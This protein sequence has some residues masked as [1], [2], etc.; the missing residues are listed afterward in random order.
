MDFRDTV[1]SVGVLPR[2]P[3]PLTDKS[4][5]ITHFRHALALD[6]LRVKFLPE[7]LN[8][9][10]PD[11]EQ[12]V[13]EVWF[14]GTH[15]DVG[16]GNKSNPTLDRG[17]EPLKWMMEEAQ[18]QGL[19]VRLHDV[20]IGVPH[21]EVTNS[22]LRKWLI[23]EIL[24]IS[25]K[26]YTLGGKSVVLRRP[27]LMAARE[28]LP[29]HSI[30]WTVGASL[31]EGSISRLDSSRKP[32]I[33][34]A[35][36][37]GKDAKQI[38]WKDM[39]PNDKRRKGP[40]WADDHDFT[41]MVNILKDEPRVADDVW[42][43]RLHNYVL[44]KKRSRP[45][46]IWAYGRPQFLQRLFKNYSAK[47]ETASIAR[48]IIGFNAK[49]VA[50][51]S[52]TSSAGDKVEEERLRD[53]VIPRI[54]LMLS[55]W[56]ADAN[57]AEAEP[58]KPSLWARALGF[59]GIGSS[60]VNVT[61]S[62]DLN[63][64]L[65]RVS[66]EDRSMQLARTTMDLVLDVTK[67]NNGSI[68]NT[69][70]WPIEKAALAE[71]ALNAMV[72][73]FS[74]EASKIEFYVNAISNRLA[75]LIQGKQKYPKLALQTMRTVA[76]LS[77][78]ISCAE[79][80]AESRIINY[81]FEIIR[82]EYETEDLQMKQMLIN[83]AF[84]TLIALSNQSSSCCLTIGE[85]ENMKA[86]FDYLR[87]G[88]H[89]NAILQILGSLSACICYNFLD[90]VG[91]IASFMDQNV[92]AS[93][94]LANL[95]N[96]GMGNFTIDDY[97]AYHKEG[98]AKRA[99]K[100]LSHEQDPYVR[101]S[102][103]LLGNLIEREIELRASQGAAI[104][105]L[106]LQPQV[107]QALI[108]S[109]LVDSRSRVTNEELLS[110]IVRFALREPILD[111]EFTALAELASKGNKQAV[112]AVC[113]AAGHTESRRELLNMFI[114]ILVD[115]VVPQNEKYVKDSIEVTVL[116]LEKGYVIPGILA[117]RL[118]DGVSGIV[119]SICR[120][121]YPSNNTYSIRTRATGA[122]LKLVG[123]LCDESMS[124]YLVAESGIIRNLVFDRPSFSTLDGIEDVLDRVSKFDNIKSL[125]EALEEEKKE[126][127]PEPE[128]DSHSDFGDSEWQADVEETS[129]L[130]QKD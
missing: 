102:A 75:P 64:S 10:Y 120:D 113:A 100:L 101:A 58:E 128:S 49:P 59:F 106:V 99:L 33:P 130:I 18:A 79:D 108:A 112:L 119:E 13:Q 4:E 71:G 105:P 107:L 129:P 95:A 53:M 62:V 15:S 88:K 25:W 78:N 103:C 6:E 72:A 97:E 122:A 68:S 24:P 118:V 39:K 92:D 2:K 96:Q 57:E 83:E 12:T 28:V 26:R 17:G 27:H 50:S 73:L 109:L 37:L 9:N 31:D 54:I 21:A 66:K 36:V 111:N 42:F 115:M 124:R 65:T 47:S 1:A 41:T 94:T 51:S 55:Q 114:P 16:G 82:E 48:S 8:E 70:D 69:V 98:V 61:N 86:L 63:W 104:K 30:H 23:L 7:H 35:T 56:I 5:H 40:K 14:A 22:M 123:L 46:V 126:A 80:I 38:D 76:L 125:I 43:S 45:D 117:S 81:L 3:F 20:K 89:V 116:L 74:Y 67:T 121:I 93:V 32:Y 77:Q 91:A 44:K 127:E 60:P 29:H 19:S 52:E 85:D 34:K 11:V 110:S 90:Y 84:A 87:G